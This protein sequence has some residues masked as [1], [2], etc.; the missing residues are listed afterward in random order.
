MTP[1]EIDKCKND[2]LVF[3]GDFC[4]NNALDF[5]WKLKAEERK[6]KYKIV[7][8]NLQLH[9]HNASGFDTSIILNYLPCDKHIVDNI[10]N[11]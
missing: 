10:K 8:Y 1:D 4:I 7:D 9:A 5:F 11:G 6:V 3:D 2:T